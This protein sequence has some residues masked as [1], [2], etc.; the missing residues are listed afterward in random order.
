MNLSYS[1]VVGFLIFNEFRAYLTLA[2][3][4]TAEL[5]LFCLQYQ[6]ICMVLHCP[7]VAGSEGF[8]VY[9][10]MDAKHMVS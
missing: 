10:Q 5:W 1:S 4:E 8:R 3:M 2:W 7:V 9:L 6:S